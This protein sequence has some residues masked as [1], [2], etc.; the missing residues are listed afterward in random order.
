MRGDVVRWTARRLPGIDPALREDLLASVEQLVE[1][2]NRVDRMAEV[3]S[4]VGFALRSASR[5]GASDSRSE[6]IRQGLRV[7]A[8]VLA[9]TGAL[10]TWTGASEP[11]GVAMALVAT[12][13]AVAVA[14]G[15]RLGAVALAAGQ[16]ALVAGGAGGHL[17]LA[18]IVLAAVVAGHRFDAR[19]CPLG[20]AVTAVTLVGIGVLEATLPM[21]TVTTMTMTT[22]LIALA[23]I[24][25]VA[26]LA[27]GW[28]D[29]RFAVAGTLVWAWPATAL[30]QQQ[31]WVL[32]ALAVVVGWQVSAS[33]LDRC[34][35]VYSH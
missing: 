25:P 11:R 20:A 15:S 23:A 13:V 19:H 2:R 16:V 14:G 7:G 35:T 8:L 4:L 31:V 27:V 22:V 32:A 9:I 34:L 30:D 5:R 18:V 10:L 26:L 33:A 21:A 17:P 3:G 6:L 24:V 29:P 1:R 28:F 12:A